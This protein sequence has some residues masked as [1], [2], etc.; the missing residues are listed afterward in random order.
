ML[1]LFGNYTLNIERNGV[2]SIGAIHTVEGLTNALL[3]LLIKVQKVSKL[4]PHC[5][6]PLV[7]RTERH[8]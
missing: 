1:G 5:S 2:P 7:T 8:P 3:S 4:R 6:A